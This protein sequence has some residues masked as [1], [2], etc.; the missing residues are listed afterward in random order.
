MVSISLIYSHVPIN[1]AISLKPRSQKC[2]YAFFHKLFSVLKMSFQEIVDT[3]YGMI[4]TH[5]KT[6]D[7]L[8]Y[9]E[10]QDLEDI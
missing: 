6:L 7:S 4:K 1:S 10:A 2:F 5:F 9:F 3:F 8:L